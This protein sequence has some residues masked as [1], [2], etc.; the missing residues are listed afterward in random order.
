M[1]IKMMATITP[2]MHILI[3]MSFHHMAFLTLL[4]PLLKPCAD[5]WRLSVL[6]CSESSRS[7]RSDTL[8]MLSLIIPTVLSI[9][10]IELALY[11]FSHSS[12][13]SMI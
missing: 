6:S 1:A 4:A 10:W 9:S 8:L 12:T 13:I 5:L 2:M 7:P 11:I 3:F